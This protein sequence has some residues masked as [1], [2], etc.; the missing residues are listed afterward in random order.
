MAKR[1]PS[2]SKRAAQNRARREARDARSARAGEATAISEGLIAPIGSA[3]TASTEGGTGD[4]QAGKAGG[5]GKGKSGAPR[6]KGKGWFNRPSPYSVPG[7][8][9]VTMA[10]MFAVVSAAVLLISPL[11]VDEEV[12]L[13]D[14]RVEAEDLE[15]L[16]E[17]AETVEILVEERIFDTR[18]PGLA[19]ALL[20]APTLITGA[21]MYYTKRPKRATVWNI[22]LILLAMYVVVSGPLAILALP[23]VIAMGIGTFQTRKALA[24]EQR[25]A[26]ESGD[27]IEVEGEPIDNDREAVT[28]GGDEDVIE[29]EGGV[30][31]DTEVDEDGGTTTGD[32]IGATSY[33]HSDGDPDPDGASNR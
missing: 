3:G 30:V 27:I 19:V 15:D 31:E 1:N 5:R 9:A 2:K 10:F 25:A 14:P 11:Q 7:Q 23:A 28:D 24:D 22:C 20:I 4:K 18:S 17:D 21:A 33:E 29:V 8:R 32:D 16:P 12:P 6:Q 13:D 26:A